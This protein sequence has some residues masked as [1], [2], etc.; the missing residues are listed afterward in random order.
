MK[1]FIA[2]IALA[3]AGFGLMGCGAKANEPYKDVHVSGH[4]DSPAMVHRMPDGFSNFAEKCDGHGHR[5]FTLFHS[6]SGY[7]GIAVIDDPKCN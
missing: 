3:A 2:G 6:D 4:D 1:R 7:G 5:V